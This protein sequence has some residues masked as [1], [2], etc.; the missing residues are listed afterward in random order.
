[1]LSFQLL[2]GSGAVPICH[3]VATVCLW[4]TDGSSQRIPAAPHLCA[5]GSVHILGLL[6]LE[7]ILHSCGHFWLPEHRSKG[8]KRSC[9]SAIHPNGELAVNSCKFNAV[10]AHG[11]FASW[12]SWRALTSWPSTEFL[13]YI[14][15]LCGCLPYNIMTITPILLVRPSTP[16]HLWQ[17]TSGISL[18]NTLHCQPRQPTAAKHLGRLP[19]VIH[20][21]Q[22]RLK[23]QASLLLSASSYQVVLAIC[24]LCRKFFC[25]A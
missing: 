10:Q 23:I 11:R 16:T 25:T 5:T 14:V 12:L 7:E 3:G 6:F 20:H 8:L 9:W 15:T 24:I 21:S 18:T 2:Q 22:G 19:Q 4:H 13:G 1:M 17:F